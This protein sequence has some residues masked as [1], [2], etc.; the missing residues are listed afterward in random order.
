[1]CTGSD[2]VSRR[3]GSSARRAGSSATGV[4]DKVLHVAKDDVGFV[5]HT[6]KNCLQGVAVSQD[7]QAALQEEQAALQLVLRVCECL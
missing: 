1:M 3:A 7:E 5:C 6:V 4:S 2:G